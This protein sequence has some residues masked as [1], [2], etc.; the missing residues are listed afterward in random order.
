V[1]LTTK[2]STK[3]DN[4]IGNNIKRLRTERGMTQK[5]L[6]DKLFVSA[7]AVSRWENNE[8]EPSITTLTELAKI[9][10]VS[11]DEI[12]GLE[13]S[14]SE[15]TEE[16]KEESNKGA[17]ASTPSEASSQEEPAS[18]HKPL[19]YCTECSAPLY[20]RD[21]IA[22]I[23]EENVICKK[24]NILN[25]KHQEK[26]HEQENQ[27]SA[28]IPLTLCTKC[29]S[30]IYDKEDI[31]RLPDKS[32]LCKKCNTARIELE[33]LVRKDSERENI[34]LG[35][36]RRKISF[37]VSGLILFFGLITGLF[38]PAIPLALFVSCLIL[39]N[40]F[41]GSVCIVIFSWSFITWPKLIFF[42]DFDI[43][44]CLDGCLFFIGIK[45]IL[46]ILGLVISIL[47]SL[48][49]ISIG[50]VLSIFVY[51]YAIY[52]NFNDPG[53]TKDMFEF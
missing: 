40:N 2:Q 52:K 25:I 53:Y 42:F 48:L 43:G 35:K 39:K 14:K 30:P 26:K 24:C 49:A 8:V 47:L 32:V 27:R 16:N 12:L 38:F 28:R 11:A 20:S 1:L 37:I 29:N 22:T 19:T 41:V 7:Q 21:D 23:Q 10:G 15:N 45:I 17:E 13:I 46:G 44:G 18:P 50:S 4:M 3:G 9:F 5:A 6:A 31:V 34:A 33:E 36:R 51:P